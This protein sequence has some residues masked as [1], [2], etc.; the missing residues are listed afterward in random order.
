MKEYDR[1]SRVAI[2]AQL[3][4]NSIDDFGTQV[5][6]LTFRRAHSSKPPLPGRIDRPTSPTTQS[7]VSPEKVV[8]GGVTSETLPE[9]PSATKE[10]IRQERIFQ[11]NR[12]IAQA[13]AGQLTTEMRRFGN[14]HQ[15]VIDRVKRGLS[16]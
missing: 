8:G 6:V 13:A 5:M 11:L 3:N 2:R 10:D 4:G 9:R 16:I 15:G 1:D 7:I 12:F 14:R